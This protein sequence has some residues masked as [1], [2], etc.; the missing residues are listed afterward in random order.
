MNLKPFFAA[1]YANFR[2][3]EKKSAQIREICGR[4]FGAAFQKE[5][6]R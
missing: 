3:W 4:G 2:G 1:N 5:H 6:E